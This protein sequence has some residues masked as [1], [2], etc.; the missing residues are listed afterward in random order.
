MN[1]LETEPGVR[2]DLHLHSR[3]SGT[4]GNWW[5]RGLG[6]GVEARES[7]TEPEAAYRMA[8]DA[9]MDFVTLTDHETIEG[10]LELVHHE[11]FFVGEEV[12]AAFPEDGSQVDVLVY[13]ID[14]EVHRELQARRGDVYE[15]VDYLREEGV[16]HVLAHPMYGMPGN[17]DRAQVEKRLVLFGI[18]EFINGS[19][20]AGQNRLAREVA[21]RVGTVEL[22]QMAAR[23][24]LAVPPHRRV[25][26]TGG[27]DDHGGIYGGATWTAA[28]GVKSPAEF[29]AA[30][31][32]GEVWPAGADGS[33]AGLVHTGL[34]IADAAIREDEGSGRRAVRSLERLVLQPSIGRYL[35]WSQTSKR[36]VL[37]HVPLLARL[38]EPAIRSAL[39][40]HYER[41]LAGAM[42]GV[43]SGFPVIDFLGSLGDFIDGH[44]YVAP[45]LGA[46]GYF[47]REQRKA[48]ELQRELFPGGPAELKAGV[49]VDGMD[50]VHGVATMYTNLRRRL[51]AGGTEERV[52][53]VRCGGPA[54]AGTRV[55]RPVTE[56]PV[57]LYDDLVLGVPSLL[58]VMEHV[59]EEGYDVLHVATPGPLGLAALVCG[60]ALGVPVVGAYHTEFGDYARAL[61][62]DAFVAELVEVAVREFYER[63][64]VVAVPSRATE[65]SLRN[66]GYRIR[67]FRVL[68]N[69]VDTELYDPSR[70]D[71]GLREELGGGRKLLLYAG[72]VSREKGLEGL[73][74]GYLSLKRRRDDVHLVVAGDGPYRRGL[75]RVLG[76]KATF[77]GFLSGEELARLYASCDLFVFP[78]TTD[79]LGR[80]VVEAQ[81]SGLPA[82]VYGTGGPRE[83][84]RPGASGLVVRSGDGAGFFAAVEELLDDPARRRRMGEEAREFAAGLSWEAV[85]EDLVELHAAV[86][87]LRPELEPA[88]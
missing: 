50:G 18:W 55:L 83:C 72:R 52:Q 16:V 1:R 23:R 29:L 20:P 34:R 15:L 75:E 71:L 73:A 81:A 24:G 37:D 74:A 57:P 43:G 86:A 26:G 12:S 53:V 2:A 76:D 48:R 45:Y 62:G 85:L 35:R 8:K 60:L 82:V 38:E 63:C 28:A 9:G 7:Y 61:S 79:T 25:S 64:S 67:R 31:A 47:G 33:A 6:A 22:R 27:S 17:L 58:E 3:A 68:K 87:G 69:G 56:L 77:T 40:G 32:A 5:V 65:L 46:H 14:S 66:R 19:R 13:G 4:A 10:A 30:L 59:V 49:F 80:A 41:K 51:A 11:D 36:K 54:A 21:E 88:S 39:A 70:R 42:G 84:I 78:S 44:L